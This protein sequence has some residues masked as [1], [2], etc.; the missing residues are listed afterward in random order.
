MFKIYDE[1]CMIVNLNRAN[2]F[3]LYI[4]FKSTS[5]ISQ[6]FSSF[7]FYFCQINLPKHNV[8]SKILKN[9]DFLHLNLT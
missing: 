3:F 7:S 4:S 1:N 2:Y 8:Q 9:H 5:V 6:K